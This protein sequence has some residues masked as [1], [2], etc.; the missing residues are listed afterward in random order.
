MSARSSFAK[1]R[2]RVRAWLR[3]PRQ[4]S[5]TRLGWVYLVLTGGVGLGALNTGNNLLYL[6]LGMLLSVIVLSGVLSERALRDVR[7][8][9]LVP[10]GAFAGETFPLRYEVRRT[11]GTAFALSLVELTEGIAARAFVPVVAE[12]EP[13]VVRADAVAKRRGP[14]RLVRLKLSTIFPLGLFEKS[15]EFDL[16]DVLVV[17]P[18]K[19]FACEPNAD[20]H[21]ETRGDAGNPRHR[22]GTGD[23]LGLKELS[24]L[25][26][27]R[28][29]HWKKSAA[30][31]KLLKTE[32]ER[33]D[34]RQYTLSVDARLGADALDRACEEAAAMTRLLIGRGH[35][36]GLEAGRRRLRPG[37]GPGQERRVLT[38]LAWVGFDEEPR[39]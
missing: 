39:A 25:E 11:D 7:V 10:D 5:V 24:P 18:K 9:R 12:A 37:A 26:D 23:L 16:E 1:L 21:G 15:R 29:V 17:F 3:P 30:V 32:R 28:R 38:A 20:L 8:R 35:E 33:E 19:G 27:A 4:L 36:V 2:A 22:D 6:V 34:R 13:V 31:G 14:L